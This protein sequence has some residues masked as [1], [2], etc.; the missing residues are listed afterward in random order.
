MRFN[1]LSVSQLCDVGYNVGFHPDK[2][3]VKHKN[4]ENVVLKGFRKVNLYYVDLSYA[5]N[6]SIK[7]L[8]QKKRKDGYDIEDLDISI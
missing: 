8:N 5:S 4:L 1:L 7:C 2:C 6:P 3:L